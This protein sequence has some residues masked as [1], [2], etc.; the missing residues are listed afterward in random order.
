MPDLMH[1]KRTA[2][3][4]TLKDKLREDMNTA[5][6]R[7]DKDRARL[8]SMVLA[9]VHNKEIA[10]GHDLDDDE[11][12]EVITRGVKQRNEAAEQMASRPELVEK[13]QNEAEVLTGYL[14]EQLGEDEIRTLVAEVIEEGADN[15]GAVMGSLIPRTRGRANGREVN[16]IAREEL[17]ARRASN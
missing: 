17:M 10:V 5:R 14:P 15:I 2:M 12:V 7:K 6:R 11:V 4:A 3:A 13:E 9:E 1:S 16:R 8:L